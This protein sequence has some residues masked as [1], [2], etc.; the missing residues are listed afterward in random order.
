MTSLWSALTYCKSPETLARFERHH[1][2]YVLLCFGARLKEPG[3]RRGQCSVG[4]IC[5]NF[6]FWG[7]RKDEGIPRTSRKMSAFM[8]RGII[9]DEIFPSSSRYASSI[10]P[11]GNWAFS[12][13]RKCPTEQFARRLRGVTGW[14]DAS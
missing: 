3:N 6:S 12:Y 13:S 1:R 5:G 11:F 8:S 2:D 9:A 4:F 7:L 14:Q 10:G